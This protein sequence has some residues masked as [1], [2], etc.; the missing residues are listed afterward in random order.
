MTPEQKA[1]ASAGLL[2]LLRQALPNVPD[3]MLVKAL[4]VGISVEPREEP[5]SEDRA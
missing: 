4:P 1:K 3:S 5:A 2:A